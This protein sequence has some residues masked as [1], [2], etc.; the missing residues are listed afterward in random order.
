[1]KYKFFLENTYFTQKTLSQIFQNKRIQ[2]ELKRE[3]G[4]QISM[5]C[6]KS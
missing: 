6:G 1:M 5:K 3:P 4:Q 2:F